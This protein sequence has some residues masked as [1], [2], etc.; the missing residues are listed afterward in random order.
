M[1][2]KPLFDLLNTLGL[3]VA[4]DHFLAKTEPPFLLYRF[5]GN[6]PFLA[7][8]CNYI[9]ENNYI[10]DLV[11]EYKDTALEQTLE[12]LLTDNHIPFTKSEDYIESE[13]IY[14]IRY[15]I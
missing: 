14:Q 6:N 1:L 3:N 13:R 8:D 11:T 15:M 9:N 7:D 4:Y 10:I 12:Q 2:E 5:V